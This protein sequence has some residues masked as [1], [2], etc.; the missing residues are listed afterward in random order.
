MQ[1]TVRAEPPSAATQTEFH[2]KGGGSRE[3]S[4]VAPFSSSQGRCPISSLSWAAKHTGLGEPWLPAS[5]PQLLGTPRI[6]DRH[7]PKA[8]ERSYWSRALPCRHARGFPNPRAFRKRRPDPPQRSNRPMG[9]EASFSLCKTLGSFLFLCI[10]LAILYPVWE[11]QEHLR[12][13]FA[14][15]HMCKPKGSVV[16]LPAGALSLAVNCAVK[17]T[18]PGWQPHLRD[19]PS[20]PHPAQAR[21][22]KTKS[23]VLH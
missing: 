4:W 5:P 23:P 7:R 3:E 11:F 21:C 16:F 6:L 22:T 15:P 18:R 12:L 19:S 10:L 9:R 1:N 20:L 2:S 13:S 17:R 14:Q 8:R